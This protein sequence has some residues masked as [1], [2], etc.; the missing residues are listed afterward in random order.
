MTDPASLTRFRY[1][2]LAGNNTSCGEGWNA[3]ERPGELESHLRRRY[4]AGTSRLGAG[5]VELA[6]ARLVALLLAGLPRP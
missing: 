3:G 2:P 1:P 5:G 6:H 4:V